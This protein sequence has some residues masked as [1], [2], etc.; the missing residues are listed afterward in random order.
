LFGSH[1]TLQMKKKMGIP[2]NRPLANFLPVITIKAKDP[3]IEITNFDVKKKGLRGKPKITG[4]HVQN[5]E[6]AGGLLAESGIKP[7]EL[8]P[9]EDIKKLERR[10]KA[11]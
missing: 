7:E 10:V 6:D 8:P 1:T 3:A 11:D 4:E 2:E 9:E 5:N